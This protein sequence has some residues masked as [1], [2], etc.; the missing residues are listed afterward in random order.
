[1]DDRQ[2]HQLV[3]DLSVQHFNKPF[4]D[5]ACFNYRLRTTGGRYLPDERKI[6]INPK[7]LAELGMNE[8]IGII[9]HELCHYH[10]H[11]EGKN[12]GHRDKSFR[13][14]LKRTNSPRHC[15]PLPSQKDALPRYKYKC[16]SCGH[17]YKR[18]RKVNINKYRCG[19][20]KGEIRLDN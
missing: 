13:E 3:N 10:L 14:L 16:L 6:E 7:Y 12:F 18:K 15:Q 11:I 1:M 5:R 2:L 9:K 17:L 19:R 20:C 4:I 8:M